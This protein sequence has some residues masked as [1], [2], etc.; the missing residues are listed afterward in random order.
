MVTSEGNAYEKCLMNNIVSSPNQ[1][2]ATLPDHLIV[3]EILQRLP[4]KT[5]VRFKSVSKFWFCIISSPEFAKKH[6][7]RTS[8]NNEFI[9]LNSLYYSRS[10]KFLSLPYDESSNLKSPIEMNFTLDIP[11]RQQLQTEKGRVVDLV[12]SCNGLVCLSCLSYPTIILCYQFL[13]ICNPATHQYHEINNPSSTIFYYW[14][15]YIPSIDDYKIFA[16]STTSLE[17]YVYSLSTGEWNVLS[18]TDTVFRYFK[19][20]LVP[21]QTAVD[22]ILYWSIVVSHRKI[23]HI[24][25][26]DIVNLNFKEFPWMDWLDRYSRA[27]FFEMNGCLS[28]LCY[29]LSRQPQ[30]DVWT[31]KQGNEWS[32]WEKMFSFDIGH[33]YLLHITSNGKFLAQNYLKPHISQ[34]TLI[35]PSR[36]TLQQSS[37]DIYLN[38][39]AA[40]GY[41]ES[42]VSPFGA[43]KSTKEEDHEV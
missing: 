28:L 30:A 12:G 37:L 11:S 41:V 16:A 20:E 31:L 21:L 39:V 18:H 40:R 26:V 19:P 9:L 38:M 34:I 7:N 24:I 35:D 27:S 17:F 43:I 13:V 10:Y 32:S 5:L 6:L 23:R 4:V 29:S 22:D 25:G 36:D 14:F 8:D 1:I 33:K 3:E 2:P 42:L 15:G